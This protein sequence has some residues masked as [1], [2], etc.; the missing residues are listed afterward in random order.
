MAVKFKYTGTS[1]GIRSRYPMLEFRG[2]EKTLSNLHKQMRHIPLKLGKNLIRAARF[3]Q[4]EAQLRTP[5]DTGKLVAS[6]YIDPP[7]LPPGIIGGT[8]EVEIGYSA[9]YAPFVHEQLP[10]PPRP[11][12]GTDL[13]ED[14]VGRSRRG[15]GK[16][17]EQAKFLENAIKDNEDRILDIIAGVR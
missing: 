15:P 13:P 1:G 5:V 12:H 11:R 10:D 17:M 8:M 3:I 2:L 7:S 6:A 16:P 9:Q 4:A 14:Y